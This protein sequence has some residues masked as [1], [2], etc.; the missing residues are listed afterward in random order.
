VTEDSPKTAFRAV[1]DE[2][3]DHLKRR[4]LVRESEPDTE[5][6]LSFVLPTSVEKVELIS[7]LATRYS[8]PL[9]AQGAMTAYEPGSGEGGILVRFDLMRR[10]R[11]PADLQEP[12]VEAEAGTL[13]LELWRTSSTLEGGVSPSIS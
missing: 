5:I 6:P 3:E 13:C 8:V 12:W 10:T 2:F 7:E 9:V 1:I 11:L 4:L